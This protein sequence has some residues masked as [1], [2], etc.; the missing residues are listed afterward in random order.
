[1]KTGKSLQIQ[2]YTKGFLKKLSERVVF[3]L[4]QFLEDC[5]HAAVTP[6]APLPQHPSR[7]LA[8]LKGHR[9]LPIGNQVRFFRFI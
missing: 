9:V 5:V 3:N 8:L 7:H 4:F 6:P 2:R 1:M